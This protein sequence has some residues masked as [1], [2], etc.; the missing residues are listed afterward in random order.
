M[1]SWVSSVALL[2]YRETSDGTYQVLVR[3]IPGH[4][5]AYGIP[6]RDLETGE[7][8]INCARDVGENSLGVNLAANSLNLK[9]SVLV[10]ETGELE[11]TR[12][13]LVRSSPQ[14]EALAQLDDV[15]GWKYT[16]V[17]ISA[18]RSVWVTRE[19]EAS[20]AALK[21]ALASLKALAT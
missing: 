16:F 12:V 5:L 2:V 1:A 13:F 9:D 14:L 4:R 18:L 21:F 3:F 17:H 8:E 7:K 19:I 11:K 10:S 6:F 15:R 20:G